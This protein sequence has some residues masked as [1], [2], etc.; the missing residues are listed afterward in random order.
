VGDELSDPALMSAIGAKLVCRPGD[1]YKQYMVDS[2]PRVVLDQ[3]TALVCPTVTNRI[4]SNNVT[5]GFRIISSTG[6]GQ[7][8][9]WTLFK[10]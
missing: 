7:T 9:I 1:L 3:L 5:Q 8:L 4:L 6:V 2:P 10:E